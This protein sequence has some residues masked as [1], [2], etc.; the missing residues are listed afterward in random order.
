VDTSHIIVSLP[1]FSYIVCNSYPLQMYLLF[2][3][4]VGMWFLVVS[5]LV[6][7]STGADTSTSSIKKITDIIIKSRKHSNGVDAY[8]RNVKLRRD[9]YQ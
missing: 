5:H 3:Y 2:L 4:S 1:L 7:L 9:N 6:Q 8:A